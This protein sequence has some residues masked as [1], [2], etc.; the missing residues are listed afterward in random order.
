M[1]PMMKKFVPHYYAGDKGALRLA[2]LQNKLNKNIIKPNQKTVLWSVVPNL[3]GAEFIA[4]EDNKKLPYGHNA[5]DQL[6]IIHGFDISEERDALMAEAARAVRDHGIVD[7][8]G[9]HKPYI[10]H[11]IPLWER[12]RYRVALRFLDFYSLRW[13]RFEKVQN[14]MTLTLDGKT[15]EKSIKGGAVAASYRTAQTTKKV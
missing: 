7:V 11:D 3:K 1:T 5:L 14:V 10:K 13:R 4:F 15:Q 9:W 2:R 12:E 8:I 6:I